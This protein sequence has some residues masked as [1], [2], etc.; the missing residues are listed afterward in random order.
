MFENIG[1]WI[2]GVIPFIGG[3]WAFLYYNEIIPNKDPEGFEDW[4]NRYGKIIVIASPLCILFGV[5]KLLRI[6]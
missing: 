2:D 4:K 1:E 5:L 3:L 6:M